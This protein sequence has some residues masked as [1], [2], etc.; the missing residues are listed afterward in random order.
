M[1]RFTG[2]LSSKGQVTLPVKA[3]RELGMTTGDTLIFTTSNSKLTIERPKYTLESVFGSVQ[4]LSGVETDD[5]DDLIDEAMNAHADEF[6]R[7]FNGDD[8]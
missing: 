8:E 3:R 6:M 7:R 1:A 5:F 4:S 2:K